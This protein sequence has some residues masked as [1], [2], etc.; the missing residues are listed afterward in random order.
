MCG[1]Q[2][3]LPPGNGGDHPQTSRCLAANE[4]KF[5]AEFSGEWNLAICKLAGYGMGKIIGRL[6]NGQPKT[7][8]RWNLAKI[9]GQKNVVYNTSHYLYGL[10]TYYGSLGPTW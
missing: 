3:L 1:E 10:D 5:R 9:H 2:S 4:Y 6:A 7:V 8:R